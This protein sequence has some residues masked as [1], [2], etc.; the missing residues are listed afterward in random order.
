[1]ERAQAEEPEAARDEAV[2]RLLRWYLDTAQA[3]ADTVSPQRYQVRYEPR[4][5]GHPPLPF[6][7]RGSRAGLVRR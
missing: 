6:A 1:M 7:D 5:S 2:G 4:A 3:A